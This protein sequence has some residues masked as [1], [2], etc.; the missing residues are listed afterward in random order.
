VLR[1]EQSSA[2]GRVD[3]VPPL[4]GGYVLSVEGRDLMPW[5]GPEKVDGV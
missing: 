1:V 3:R 2:K 5:S 4:E